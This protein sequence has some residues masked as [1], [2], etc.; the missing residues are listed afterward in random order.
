VTILPLTSD[1]R[2]TPIFRVR[3][4]PNLTNGLRTP[5]DVM[6]DKLHTVARDKV[7]ETIGSIVDEQLVEIERAVAVWLGIA[8]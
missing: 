7:R 1:L 5:S 2:E 6:I 3:V 4:L 8:D